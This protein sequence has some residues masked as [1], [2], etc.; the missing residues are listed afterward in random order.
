MFV[1]ASEQ[2]LRMEQQARFDYANSVYLSNV[3]AAILGGGM[4]GLCLL[5]LSR[6][7][8]EKINEAKGEVP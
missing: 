2:C 5:K 6:D 7:A 1:V 3:L 4:G 8:E